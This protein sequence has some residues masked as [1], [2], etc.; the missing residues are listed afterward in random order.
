MIQQGERLQNYRQKDPS[1]RFDVSNFNIVLMT[2]SGEFIGARF[3]KRFNFS[4]LNNNNI[5][6]PGKYIVMIDPLWNETIRNDDLYKEVLVDIYA[7]E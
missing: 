3:G 5:L 4:L 2:T 7:P 6:N 1:K